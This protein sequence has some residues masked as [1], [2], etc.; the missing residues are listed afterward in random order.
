MVLLPG[1]PLPLPSHH[2]G[3]SFPSSALLSPRVSPSLRGACLSPVTPREDEGL[4]ASSPYGGSA[5]GKETHPGGVC[6]EDIS[7]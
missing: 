5:S 2:G 7:R 3:S 1:S 6:V 4:T